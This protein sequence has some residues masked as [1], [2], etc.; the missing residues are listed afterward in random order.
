MTGAY[1][2]VNGKYMLFDRALRYNAGIIF[3]GTEQT[4]GNLTAQADPRNA[5]NGNLNGS[6]RYPDLSLWS[7][8]TTPYQNTMPSLSLAYNVTDSLI[9]RASASKSITGPTRR[10]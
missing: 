6:S 1:V 7:Y 2:E 4:I 3:A 5:A 9:A 8:E 10:I